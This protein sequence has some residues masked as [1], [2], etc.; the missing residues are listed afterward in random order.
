MIC[1]M[2]STAL[3]IPEPSEQLTLFD[4][5]HISDTVEK[6][7]PT[8][9]DVGELRDGKAKLSA[10]DLY[11]ERTNTEGRAQ[12]AAT[13]R[14]L[15]VRI[16]EL[17]GPGTPGNPNLK[18]EPAGQSNRHGARDIPRREKTDAR[19]MAAHKDVVEDVIATSS[20]A[21]PA[22]TRKVIK[23][24]DAVTKPV[25]DAGLSVEQQEIVAGLSQFAFQAARTQALGEWVHKLRRL[26]VDERRQV[27]S[28]LTSDERFIVLHAENQHNIRV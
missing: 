18:P 16:G 22:S 14:H 1:H 23:A 19:K 17:L 2:T 24:I 20:D 5:Q 4:V 3:A 9:N 28:S 26:P 6:W 25:L 8:A 7:L 12:L 21:S 13:M 10:L 27:L 11:L 15:D